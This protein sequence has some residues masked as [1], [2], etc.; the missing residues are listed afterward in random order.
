MSL[1]Y[2]SNNG[3][4]AIPIEHRAEQDSLSQRESGLYQLSQKYIC[5][6][7]DIDAVRSKF[8]QGMS[9]LKGGYRGINFALF[10]DASIN[11]GV[12]FA[13]IDCIFYGMS[14]SINTTSPI[15]STLT[16][17][18]AQYEEFLG[19]VFEFI[20]ESRRSIT[21]GSLNLQ[22]TWTTMTQ[23]SVIGVLASSASVIEAPRNRLP[24]SILA[25]T[26]RDVRLGGR[27]IPNVNSF[28]FPPIDYVETG[29]STTSFGLYEERTI[30]VQTVAG[31]PAGRQNI[32][33]DL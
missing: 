8:R 25:S 2:F 28:P 29:S 20:E 3:L 12:L 10:P 6:R 11:N 24:R 33:I 23:T 14:D 30:G 7:S 32:V 17:G 22:F 13:E 4:G 18:V 19:G 27:P 31:R 26:P 1:N 9:P 15:F 21:I 5:K 16:S